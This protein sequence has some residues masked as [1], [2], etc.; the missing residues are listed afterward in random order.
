VLKKIAPNAHNILIVGVSYKKDTD[1]IEES[2]A[3]KF[4]T[5]NN[6]YNLFIYDDNVKNS[7]ILKNVSFIELAE[8]ADNSLDIDV[9]ILF[10]PSGSYEDIPKYLKNNAKLID[11]WGNWEG[12]RNSKN[13]EYL[14]M[15]EYIG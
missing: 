8:V 9:A 4:I 13:Y 12:Y 10:V 11:F 3:L 1:V 7:P 6:D 2:P 15:G 5:K 14:K